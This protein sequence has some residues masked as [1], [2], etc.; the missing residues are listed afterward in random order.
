MILTAL[1]YALENPWGTIVYEP[2]LRHVLGE[3]D[4]GVVEAILTNTPHN[5]LFVV[6]VYYGWL[7]LVLLLVFY[8]ALLRA[9]LSATRSVIELRSGTSVVL[10][11]SLWGCLVAYGINSMFHN[12]GPVCRRLVSLDC[13]RARVLRAEDIE[14]CCLLES[15]VANCDVGYAQGLG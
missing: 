1:S 6:L 11:A 3:P 5:Q 13:D 2:E 12:A 8:A 14:M 10:V 9:L 7:G 15:D 4:P